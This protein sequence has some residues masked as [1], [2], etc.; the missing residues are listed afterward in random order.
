MK[1]HIE[2]S[3]CGKG[4]KKEVDLEKNKTPN[5][6][7]RSKTD[8]DDIVLE[9]KNVTCED[10]GH[11]VYSRKSLMIH[12]EYKHIEDSWLVHTKRD[13]T[14]MTS[15]KE[16]TITKTEEPKQ[17]KL[18]DASQ[19]LSDRN[20]EKIMSKRKFEE[21]RESLWQKEKLKSMKLREEK[22]KQKNIREKAARNRN[23]LEAEKLSK[24]R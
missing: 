13:A 19:F 14:M 10:C 16:S 22:E 15:N 8:T 9:E 23:K 6:N 21:E 17:K 2:C 4:F 1:S 3:K 7:S 5:H 18:K 24:K 11:I 12:K 20:D